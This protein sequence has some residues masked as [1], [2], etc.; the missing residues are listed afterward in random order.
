MKKLFLLLTAVLI[1]AACAI[2]QTRTI[3]GTVVEAGTDEP[4][5]GAT[6]MPIGG[7][8]GTATDLDGKFT[9]NIP[10]NVNK[11]KVSFVG[12]QEQTVNAADN[13]TVALHSAAT[14][15]DEVIVVA[16]G[17]AKKSA[18]TGSASVVKADQIEGR[19]VTDAVSALSGSCSRR[20]GAVDQRPA[21]FVAFGA[22]PRYR[23]YQRFGH[24]SL[25]S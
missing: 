12:Y 11:L 6:V 25:C 1:S 7:G 5:T 4:L 14:D 22:N 19:L 9:L 20:A 15:L 3:H 10:A 13:I 23:L 2:A 21:R 17:T 16:Y 24:T 8:Q 18:Y